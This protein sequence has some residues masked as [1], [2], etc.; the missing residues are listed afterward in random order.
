[1]TSPIVFE[2]IQ[3]KLDEDSQTREEIR[4]VVQTLE[5]QGTQSMLVCLNSVLTQLQPDRPNPYY[6]ESTPYLKPTAS[7]SDRLETL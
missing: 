6:P 2:Q 3:T 1:M 4:N 7:L 5:R